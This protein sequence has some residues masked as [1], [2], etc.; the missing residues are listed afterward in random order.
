M[1][2]CSPHRINMFMM[3]FCSPHRIASKCKHGAERNRDMN[4]PLNCESQAL[5]VLKAEQGQAR[6]ALVSVS[7]WGSHTIEDHRTVSLLRE[8]DV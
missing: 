4:D 8:S 2:L 7:S 5:S 6:T 1:R 3:R